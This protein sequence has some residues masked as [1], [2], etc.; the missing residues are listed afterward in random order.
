LKNSQSSLVTFREQA[1]KPF[2]QQ[3]RLSRLQAELTEVEQRL[4]GTE[5]PAPPTPDLVAV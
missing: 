1:E 2:E 3:E 4:Q 5:E